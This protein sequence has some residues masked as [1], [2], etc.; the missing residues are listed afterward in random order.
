MALVLLGVSLMVPWYSVTVDWV[1]G[2]SV[3]EYTLQ[4]YRHDG[5]DSD[6]TISYSDDEFDDPN[7]AQ[8]YNNTLYLTITAF[9]LTIILMIF[10]LLIGLKKTGMV[11]LGVIL[12][13]LA[14]IFS[15]AA[16]IYLMGALPAAYTE[17]YKESEATVNPKTK[18]MD[19]F[20]GEENINVAGT[21]YDRVWGGATG[22]YLAIVA[23]VFTLLA[24]IILMVIIIKPDKEP[25][26][27]LEDEELPENK[28]ITEEESDES[29]T[30]EKD[31]EE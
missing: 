14:F 23:F 30:D 25:E 3:H 26:K 24:S 20:F 4:E 16:P 6:E 19:S 13:I 2:N 17:E 11:K 9:I 27:K 29:K 1:N 21:D 8:V 28:T 31:L 18:Q 10:I 7:V 15:L 12:G 22:W 5:M